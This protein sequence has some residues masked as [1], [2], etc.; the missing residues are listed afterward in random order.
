MSI[1]TKLEI[2]EP[3]PTPEINY[4]CLIRSQGQV[5]EAYSTFNHNDIV[6]LAICLSRRTDTNDHLKF[7]ICKVCELKDVEYLPIG[8]EFIFTQK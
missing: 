8:S 7:T 4:P 6:L 1:N 5:F 3:I 2:P